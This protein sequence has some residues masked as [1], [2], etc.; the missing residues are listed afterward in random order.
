MRVLSR[1]LGAAIILACIASAFVSCPRRD[2]PPPDDADLP[3]LEAWA[4]GLLASGKVYRIDA[5]V[6][7]VRVD[8]QVWSQLPLEEKHE[9]VL[10]FSKY[11]EARGRPGR[12]TVV[13]I[14]NDREVASFSRYGGVNIRE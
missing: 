13:N 14:R 4:E 10:W 1:L 8:P 6:C 5:D 9:L 2:H 11:F 7:R 3:A 12:V